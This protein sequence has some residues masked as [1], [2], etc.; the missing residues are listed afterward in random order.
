MDW[1]IPDTPDELAALVAERARDA[2][3]ELP[4][5]A[6]GTPGPTEAARRMAGAE[7]AV[8]LSTAGLAGEPDLRPRDLTASVPAGLR[9]GDLQRTLADEGLWL[10]AGGPALRRSAGG[11]VAAGAAGPW[12]LSFGD[13][14]RQLL[15]CRLV[16][17]SGT[18]ARWGRAV[19]KDVA[20][21]GT[22]RAVLGSFGR[23]GVLHRAV[24]RVWPRPETS[25]ALELVPAD[26]DDLA[27]AARLAGSDLDDRVRPDALRW[28]RT[29]G[30]AAAVPIEA[31][32]VGPE[33]SVAGRAD[34]LADVAGELGLRVQGERRGLD[35]ADPAGGREERDPG[36]GRDAGVSVAEL[37]PGRGEFGIVLRRAVE[38]MG[39]AAVR[40][41]GHPLAGVLRC[42]WRTDDPPAAAERLLSAAGDAPVRL[43]RGTARELAATDDRRPEAALA[44]EER[45]LE[46]LE[47]R[48]RHWL[49]AWL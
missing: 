14:G 16:T 4:L 20:G 27:A 40:W 12:D 44:L 45:V 5:L 43:L 46:A 35:L 17:W 39:N 23:L 9:L 37:R 33:A 26:G 3:P 29:A 34:R 7:D 49:S 31:W 30:D 24:F 25:R 22:T 28:E 42:A 1:L 41:T 38:A 13:L 10:A 47:G 18:R 11:A 6:T 19:M 21:Y 8:V 32:L 48:P 15:A 36:A 2:D